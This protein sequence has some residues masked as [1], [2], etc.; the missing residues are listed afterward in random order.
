M[1]GYAVGTRYEV[2]LDKGNTTFLGFSTVAFWFVSMATTW[3][4]PIAWR[5][6]PL[7]LL[8]FVLYEVAVL[9]RYSFSHFVVFGGGSYI[10]TA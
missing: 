9:R 3:G 10:V 4:W 1:N 5:W 8:F 7:P 2:I 6:L